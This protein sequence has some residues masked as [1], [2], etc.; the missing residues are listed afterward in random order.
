MRTTAMD[1][2]FTE[3][4]RPRWTIV[5]AALLALVTIA[6]A[7][8][9]RDGSWW[10]T[11]GPRERALFVVGYFDGLAGGQR[12][13]Q[14]IGVD[15][16]YCAGLKRLCG[17][18]N[19]QVAAGLDQFYAADFRNLPIELNDAVMLVTM[20][21]AGDSNEHLHALVDQLRRQATVGR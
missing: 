10:K 4:R 8:E 17:I 21:A 2:H 14:G 15:R 16:Q 19:D 20:A 11:L 3:T 13:A 1:P 12:I 5:A 6:G 9:P 7:D 18:D